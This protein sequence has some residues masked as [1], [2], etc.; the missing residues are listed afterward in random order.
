MMLS[1]K[2]CAAH[3]GCNGTKPGPPAADPGL[4]SD[5][6]EPSAIVKVASRVIGVVLSVA[7]V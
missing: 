7:R 2:P 6:I 5:L 1:W 4:L 3:R